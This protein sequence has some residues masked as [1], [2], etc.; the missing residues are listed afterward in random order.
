MRKDF[1]KEKKTFELK[2]KEIFVGFEQIISPPDPSMC[3]RKK[4]VIEPDYLDLF[5]LKKA[6]FHK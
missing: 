4:Y 1:E 2:T 5:Y 3:R 6:Q